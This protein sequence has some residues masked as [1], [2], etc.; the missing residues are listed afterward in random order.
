M[1]EL[2]II[3][4]YDAYLKSY[5]AYRNMDKT[6]LTGIMDSYLSDI[7]ENKISTM[8]EWMEY[9]KGVNTKIES[10]NKS[11][12][13]VGVTISTM[14]KSKGLEWDV[15]FILGANEG[16]IPS[17]K[18]AKLGDIEEE[19]RLFYVAATRARKELYISYTENEMGKKS[20]FV[21]EFFGNEV[22]QLKKD[23]GKKKI[24]TKGQK[25]IHS[26][27]GK[28]TIVQIQKEKVDVKFD[29]HVIIMS[30]AKNQLYQLKQA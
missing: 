17:P 30:F 23:T 9:A 28:G 1:K 26:K 24:F 22:P 8:E 11:R 13:K 5:S 19:R 4:G 21:T 20:I 18:V 3:G 14:H 15:V 25:V 2:R 16:V 10:I 29:N 12:N 7:N 6:E 27:Y